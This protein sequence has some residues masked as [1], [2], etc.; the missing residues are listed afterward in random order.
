M[1]D[2]TGIRM[3]TT[4]WR[5]R[6]ILWSSPDGLIQGGLRSFHVGGDSTWKGIKAADRKGFEDVETSSRLLR[7]STR[8]LTLVPW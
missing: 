3:Y 4:P 1:F 6:D 2:L 8:F 5:L 7:S